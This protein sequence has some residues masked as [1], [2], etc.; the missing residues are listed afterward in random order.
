[1]GPVS[2]LRRFW[3]PFQFGGIKKI[4]ILSRQAVQ[5][6]E[7]GTETGTGQHWK[8]RPVLGSSLNFQRT[9]DFGC[10]KK[11]WNQRTGW[12][13]VFLKNPKQRISEFRA[14]TIFW[15]FQKDTQKNTNSGY[16]KTPQRT[17]GF[18]ERTAGATGQAACIAIMQGASI[19]WPITNCLPMTEHVFI[20]YHMCFI[21]SDLKCN[22]SPTSSSRNH[23][24][25][26]NDKE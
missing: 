26:A 15:V 19:D 11:H 20:S 2:V 9:A 21:V 1:L 10:S 16:F 14:N 8:K 7:L 6:N 17:T 4:K 23:L 13:R 12:F 18:Q 3:F 22:G 24:G 25:S 5:E